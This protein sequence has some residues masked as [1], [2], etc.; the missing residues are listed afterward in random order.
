MTVDQA[1]NIFRRMYQNAPPKEQVAH[2]HLFGIK[3]A[4]ELEGMPNT[5]IVR[6]AGLKPSYHSEVAKGRRLGKYVTLKSDVPT[7]WSD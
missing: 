4:L 2:I 7:T 5:E 3:Y 1:A 6:R